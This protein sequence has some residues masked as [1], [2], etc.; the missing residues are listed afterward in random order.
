VAARLS[1][2]LVNDGSDGEPPARGAA[3]RLHWRPE[4]EVP[5]A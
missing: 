3:V 1:V 2:L 4:H 5:V